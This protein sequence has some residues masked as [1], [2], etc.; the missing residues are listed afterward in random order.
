MDLLLDSIVHAQTGVIQ[1]QIVPPQLLLNS[2]QESQLFFPRDTIPPFPLNKDSTGVVYK[3]CETKVY[4]KNNKLSYVIST[5]LVN[6]GEFRVY[7]FVPVPL[8]INKGKLA[9]IKTVKSIL[10]VDSGRQYYYFSSEAELQKC[11]EPTKN[12]YVCKQEKPL[13]SSLVQ[14]DCAVR[15]LKMWKNL[16]ENCEVHLVRLT[17]TVW[18]QVNDNEWVYYAPEV[19]SVTVLCADR[20]PIDVPLRG[21]GKL[22]LDPNCKGYSKAALL[23][24]I[25]AVRADSSKSGNNQL[26][27]VKLQNECCEELGT[28][29]NLSTLKLN[30]NFRETVSHADDLKYVGIKVKDLEKHIQEEWR[31][32]HS[33]I[34]HGYSIALYVVISL[35]CLYVAYKVLRCMVTKG[36]CR[37]MAGALRLT[38]QTRANPELTGSGNIVNINIKTSNESLAGTREI[39]PLKGPSPPDTITGESETR[40][41]RRLGHSRTHF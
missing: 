21:A 33:A 25:Q 20:D 32:K 14:E 19:D 22:I 9:Y 36:L 29:L 3:V 1:P 41:A 6:K 23:Q 4:I 28:R 27:Q 31:N 12:K 5:P 38:H 30:L 40:S 39:I 8:Q 34:H 24:P 11:K 26:I 37:G 15:L 17:H 35:F 16:P 10:C 2:L 7:Y 18:T 13:L